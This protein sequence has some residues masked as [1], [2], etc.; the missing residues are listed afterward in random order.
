M[1]AISAIVSATGDPAKRGRKGHIK[2]GASHF[3]ADRPTESK[4]KTKSSRE[5]QP[6]DLCPELSS[7]KACADYCD[8]L[9][10]N[11]DATILRRSFNK[12]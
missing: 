3:F 9:Q 12:I 10:K 7:Y 6:H 11:T 8:S 4:L 5:P 2:A 1:G